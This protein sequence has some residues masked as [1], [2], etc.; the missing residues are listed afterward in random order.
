ME[1]IFSLKKYN[2]FG[3]DA[4]TRYF[5]E[6][7]DENDIRH[8]VDDE[9]YQ[10][11]KKFILGGGSNVFFKNPLF[12]GVI[13]HSVIRGVEVFKEQGDEVWV[14][15][16]S[17]ETWADFV[18]FTVSQGWRG[19]EN[20]SGVPGSVGAS[21]VQNVGAYGAEAKDCIEEVATIDIITGKKKI[22]TKNECRFGY[23][24]S[25][26]KEEKYKTCFVVS[27][28]FKLS[29]SAPLRLNYGNIRASLAARGIVAPTASDVAETVKSIRNS[30]L[31]EVGVVGSV[32]SFF[33]NTFVS[34]EHFH[35]LKNNYPDIPSY[36]ENEEKVKIPTAWFI[37]KAGLKGYRDGDAGVWD[38]QALILVNYGNASSDDIARVADKVIESVRQK[39]NIIISP[40]AVII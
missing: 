38:K 17:G 18:D 3:L 13:L 40:E 15:C 14:R 24:Q 36:P 29:K 19:L 10:R 16:G 35:L 23:R 6:V 37:E 2:T 1:Q 20:L 30:K 26:F 39:F 28:T 34:M 21:P 9:S 12:D 25:I 7:R 5:V 27:V 11:T 31:P 8:L 22:F 33:T 32:G 4:K